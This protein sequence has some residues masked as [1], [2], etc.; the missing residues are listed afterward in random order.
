MVSIS[1][2]L[3]CRMGGRPGPLE[4]EAP[5]M[6]R[7]VDNLAN[8]VES[9]LDRGFHAA[10]GQVRR[11]DAAQRHFGSPVA[12]GRGRL[13]SPPLQCRSQF[14]QSSVSDFGQRPV[15]DV[16]PEKVLKFRDECSWEPLAEYRPQ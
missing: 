1:N 16:S 3:P 4:V 9:R 15:R 8:E 14:L 7:D 12:F 6:S 2:N 10:R 11:I 13:E 5:E